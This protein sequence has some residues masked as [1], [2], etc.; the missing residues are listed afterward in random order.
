MQD[1]STHLECCVYFSFH[2][3]SL[4]FNMYSLQNIYALSLS[5]VP[6][7]ASHM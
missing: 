1:I 3:D 7:D 4:D 5:N 2:K 6:T